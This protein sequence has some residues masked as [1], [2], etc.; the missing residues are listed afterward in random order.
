MIVK[1]YNL[2]RVTNRLV[3]YM[4]V[5]EHDFTKQ[6]PKEGEKGGVRNLP[7]EYFY[8]KFH[9]NF[10]FKW[11]PNFGYKVLSDN[12]VVEIIESYKKKIAFYTKQQNVLETL[13]SL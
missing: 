1:I 2:T 12:E 7:N 9:K 10:K 6:L 5:G 3:G 13:Q 8:R 4:I 11:S